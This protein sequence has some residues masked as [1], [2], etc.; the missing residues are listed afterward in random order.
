MVVLAPVLSWPGGGLTG[1]VVR[2]LGTVF[3][4]RLRGCGARGC[5]TQVLR[6]GNLV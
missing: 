6:L 4:A 5:W 3:F 1:F 2:S